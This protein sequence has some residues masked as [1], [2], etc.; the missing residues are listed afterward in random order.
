MI[1]RCSWKLRVR[2]RRFGLS[3]AVASLFD[4]SQ[5]YF[6]FYP[7]SEKSES[8]T[9]FSTNIAHH[10][11]AVLRIHSADLLIYRGASVIMHPFGET[12]AM[13]YRKPRGFL[14]RIV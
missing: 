11:R 6:A 8:L 4:W 14:G 5:S 2:R 12:N 7:V 10:S 9:S 13:H 3:V 1:P